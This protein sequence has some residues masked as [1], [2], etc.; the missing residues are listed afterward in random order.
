MNAIQRFKDHSG[1][2]FPTYGDVLKVAAGLGYRRVIVDPE[3]FWDRAEPEE[4]VLVAQS[5]IEV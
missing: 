5:S 3:Q 1:K 2:S 4:P